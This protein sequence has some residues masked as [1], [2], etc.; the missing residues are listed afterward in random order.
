MFAIA[1]KIGIGVYTP[2][3]AAFYARVSTRV[4][5]RW[6]FGDKQGKPVIKRQLNDPSEKVVTFM[7]FIQTLAIR[8]IRNRHRLPLPKIREGVEEATTRY[9]IE[10]PLARQHTIYLFSDQ[11]GEAHG[12][13][14]I[15]R[16]GD[17]DGI[18]EKYVQVTGRAKGNLMIPSVVELFLKDLRFDPETGFASEY[19]PMTDDG[20]RIVLNPRLRFGEPVVYP[21]GYTAETLW[22]ATNTEGGIQQAADAFGVSVGE[23]NLANKY[24]DYLLLDRAA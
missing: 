22:H 2:A 11:K 1:D 24:F 18:E 3:E 17:T 9:N 13:I 4:M 14:L 8:E 23:V 6:I 20:A 21:G 19:T 16:P 15:R 5:A 10:Y 12:E 7:D